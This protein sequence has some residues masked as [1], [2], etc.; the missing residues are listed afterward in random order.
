MRGHKIGKN[1]ITTVNQWQG[2]CKSPFSTWRY[3]MVLL[4]VCN[5]SYLDRSNVIGSVII[6]RWLSSMSWSAWKR[7]MVKLNR[8]IYHPYIIDLTNEQ[9]SCEKIFYLYEGNV[10][11]TISSGPPVMVWNAYT[12]I[13]EH[14]HVFCVY[15]L[16]VLILTKITII[17][18]PFRRKY[19]HPSANLR[20]QLHKQL[21]KHPQ[22]VP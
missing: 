15:L 2:V 12:Y 10:I 18:D 22:K 21:I 9:S 11:N 7:D 19:M 17:L 5:K 3:A 6:Q 8:F 13:Y 1:D 20:H 14:L 16:K 4:L